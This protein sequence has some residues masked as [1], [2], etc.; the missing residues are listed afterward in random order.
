[1]LLRPMLLVLWLRGGSC[2]SF[3]PMLLTVQLLQ[4]HLL[5]Q[6]D[7]VYLRRLC[8][9]VYMR[10]LDLRHLLRLGD[11]VRG[12]PRGNPWVE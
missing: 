9:V 7:V 1:M 11:D 8:N 12:P 2:T 6:R 10:R 4:Q 3:C 5:L